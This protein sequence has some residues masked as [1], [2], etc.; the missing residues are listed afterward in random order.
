MIQADTIVYDAEKI[1][2]YQADPLFD[3]KSQ[4][5]M[6]E[7]SWF[8]LIARWFNSIIN[9]IFSGQFEERFT[10]P[11]MIT[12]FIMALLAVLFFLYK[13]RPEL[14]FREKKTGSIAYDIEE[15][16]IHDIDFA[17]EIETALDVKDYRLAI[18]LMYLKTLR[19]LSDNNYIDWQIHK[20]PTEY[21]YELKKTSKKKD[22]RI[23]TSY[24]LE[25]RYGNR[26]VSPGLFEK[27]SDLY[28]IIVSEQDAPA[29]TIM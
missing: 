27:V 18:R 19:Y 10:T 7:F 6:P 14:F 20:T 23:L 9:K 5:N 3:Y 28:D 29:F 24:F 16:N 11:V 13:K 8:E 26:E 17:E 4:L 15:E 12:L 2:G 22:F 21:F 1:A 25:V